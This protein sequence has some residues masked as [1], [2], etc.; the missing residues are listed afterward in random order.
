MNSELDSRKKIGVYVLVDKPKDFPLIK[1]K[2]IFVTNRLPDGSI[3]NTKP[4]M[5]RK[6][7]YKF[8]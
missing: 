8:W 7:I 4:V 1:D 2:W 5:S 6:A 3:S